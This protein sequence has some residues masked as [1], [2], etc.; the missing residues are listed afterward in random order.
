MVPELAV[1]GTVV[2]GLGGIGAAAALALADRGERVVGLDPRPVNHAEGS[3]HGHTRLVRR[4]YF[5]DPRYVPLTTRAW[6]LWRT[7]ERR[8]G[9]HLLTA[10]GVVTLAP[11]DDPE[12]LV[13]ATLEAAARFAL[14]VEGLEPA[15]VRA[16]FPAVTVPDDW[17]AVLERDAGF[18]DPEATVRVLHRLARTAGADLRRE[19][20][21]SIDLED[22]VVTTDRA[23]YRARRVVL[24]AG[25]WAP[26][27]LGDRLPLTVTRKVVAHFEPI[28][29]HGLTPD[30]LPGFVFGG[31]AFHY[32]FPLLPG[33]GVKIARHDGGE[34]TTPGTVDRVVRPEEA[35]SLRAVLAERIPAA[36][37]PLLRAY[38]C[39]YTMSPDGDFV[40]GPLPG[41][42]SC[43]VATGDSGHAFKFVPLLGELLAD[44]ALGTAPAVDIG[45][46]SP[47]R[48][49]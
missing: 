30:R 19:A 15:R 10:S 25:P 35:Q 16:R 38:T 46:L 9:E 22:A 4:A 11:P 17:E 48:F 7:L 26:E 31:D 23:R 40:L 43:I 14:P 8:S 24:A 49:G 42:P 39:L 6:D 34:P 28:D 29:P 32:G 47:A 3:S 37:G 41:A 36:A 12:Q 45:F 13:A 5:E 44:L 21:R 20:V 18:V 33:D 1:D 2:V 27:L